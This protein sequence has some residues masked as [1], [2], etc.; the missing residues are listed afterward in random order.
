MIWEFRIYI[1][2]CFMFSFSF[3]V[4]DIFFSCLCV[5][6]WVCPTKSS[7]SIICELTSL[8][9]FYLMVTYVFQVA[10]TLVF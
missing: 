6:V 7:I 8:F 4:V 10:H 1:G 9:F 2:V 3:F 5:Y